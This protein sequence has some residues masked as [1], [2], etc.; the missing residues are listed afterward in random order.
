MD[1]RL[2][3][4]VTIICASEQDWVTTPLEAAIQLPDIVSAD[5]V[6]RKICGLYWIPVSFK[7]R[8]LVTQFCFQTFVSDVFVGLQISG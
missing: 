7:L 3:P 5:V 2:I 8:I 4:D 1:L 6:R